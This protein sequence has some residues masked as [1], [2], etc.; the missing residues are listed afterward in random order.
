MMENRVERV[1]YKIDAV[2]EVVADEHDVLFRGGSDNRETDGGRPVPE[3]TQFDDAP[4]N[5]PRETE[6]PE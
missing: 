2:Q 3:N 5:E 4:E 1:E 6:P